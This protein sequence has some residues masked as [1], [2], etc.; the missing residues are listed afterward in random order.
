MDL[1]HVLPYMR[2][3]DF[4]A[5]AEWMALCDSLVPE[6]ALIECISAQTVFERMPVVGSIVVMKL[7]SKLIINRVKL[8]D[9][10][11]ITFT[12]SVN[13]IGVNCAMKSTKDTMSCDGMKWQ[14]LDKIRVKYGKYVGWVDAERVLAALNGPLIAIRFFNYSYIFLKDP[15]PIFRLLS[16]K[17]KEE[18]VSDDVTR[19]L[20]VAGHMKADVVFCIFDYL[21]MKI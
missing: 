2:C 10:P 6:I 1:K 4:T 5:E 7:R 13:H 14:Y 15:R 17:D 20:M 18:Q 21:H 3:L 16:V 19:V 9:Y 11:T 8:V 12:S